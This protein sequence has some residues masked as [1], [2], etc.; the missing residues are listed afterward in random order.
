MEF[1]GA[2][3]STQYNLDFG[4]VTWTEFWA[5]LG[6]GLDNTFKNIL[7]FSNSINCQQFKEVGEVQYTNLNNINFDCGRYKLYCEVLGNCTDYEEDLLGLREFQQNKTISSE[8]WGSKDEKTGF[9]GS[10]LIN[11]RFAI[12]AAHCHKLDED[13]VQTITIR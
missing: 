13:E 6:L 7:E 5:Q 8:G 2:P 1:P 3:F 12:S 10:T 4:F 11:D 9:C